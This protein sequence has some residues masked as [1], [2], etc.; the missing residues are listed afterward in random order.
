MRR[1]F[2]IWALVAGILLGGSS[3]VGILVRA[4]T[5]PFQEVDRTYWAPT[6]PVPA[7]LASANAKPVEFNPPQAATPEDV[8]A[9]RVLF[10]GIASTATQPQNPWTVQQYFDF[11]RM[12]AELGPLGVYRALGRP[13]TPASVADDSKTLEAA[14]SSRLGR[15]DSPFAF[16]QTQ[17]VSVARAN[18]GEALLTARHSFGVGVTRR[19]EYRRWW[20]KFGN[21]YGSYGGWQ[22]YD[23][24]EP[25]TRLRF[26]AIHSGVL[27]DRPAS[28]EPGGGPAVVVNSTNGVLIIGGDDDAGVQAVRSALS[29]ASDGDRAA[30][31][32]KTTEAAR[33]K[34]LSPLTAVRLVAE[35]RVLLLDGKPSPALAR[36]DSALKTWK[37]TP[38]AHLGR[39]AALNDLKR[40]QDALKAVAAFRAAAGN[41][42]DAFREEARAK[43]ATDAPERAEAIVRAGLREFPGAV[44]LL[45]ECY[46]LSGPARR[47]E[48]GARAADAPVPGDA[49][50]KLLHWIERDD[51]AGDGTAAV[52]TGFRRVLPRDPAGLIADAG[53]K[54]RLRKPDAA[55]KLLADGLSDE[56]QRAA[57]LA[58]F[59]R[60]VVRADRLTEGYE[61]A[62]K[63]GHAAVAFRPLAEAALTVDPPDAAR[64]RTVVTTHAAKYQTDPWANYFAGELDRRAGNFA[65]AEKQY[66]DGMKKLPAPADRK[67][68]L[69]AN[70][71]PGIVAPDATEKDWA[72]FRSQ[73]TVCLFKLGQWQ[74]AYSELW[75]KPDTFDQLAQLL[76]DAANGDGLLALIAMHA[77]LVPDDMSVVLWRSEAHW[78]KKDYQAYVDDCRSCLEKAM[79]INRFPSQIDDRWVRSLVRLNRP[80]EAEKSLDNLQADATGLKLRAIVAAAKGDVQAT[81][82]QVSALLRAGVTWA[83][84]TAD[85]D[86]GPLL[87]GEKFADLRKKLGPP[88]TPAPKK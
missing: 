18:S 64:L 1:R 47:D 41:D 2:Y 54:L 46:H 83:A 15:P 67:F 32:A 25:G 60:T 43:A 80:G 36:F 26:T 11:N 10:D 76:L 14:V 51:P 38:A 85:P 70:G 17:L 34:T 78:L 81:E 69:G 68:R 8:A 33:W 74:R 84:V 75:P 58:E 6:T 37:D 23:F 73:R 22:V 87:K 7:T 79:E 27:A 61:A 28:A 63:C 35:G 21:Q 9:F 3:A 40:H 5:P 12:A 49:L 30:A 66:A 24:D 31:A 82:T 65:A 29:A 45:A 57:L 19:I 53:A 88:A 13:A 20:V 50:T 72:D 86:L 48:A 44:G 56:E 16:T 59:A 55:V 62:L 39:A 71:P 77:K 4:I 42:P 52:V